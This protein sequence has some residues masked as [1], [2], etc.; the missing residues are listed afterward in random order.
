MNPEH[1]QAEFV[2]RFGDTDVLRTRDYGEAYDSYKVKCAILGRAYRGDLDRL[3]IDVRCLRCDGR[4]RLT[5]IAH[6]LELRCPRCDAIWYRSR[7]WLLHQNQ[8]LPSEQSNRKPKYR[9][10]SPLEERL[11]VRLLWSE[12]HDVE[13]AA[14]YLGRTPSAVNQKALKLARK[15]GLPAQ[16]IGMHQRAQAYILD[17]LRDGKPVYFSHDTLAS[18][19]QLS[20]N[21]IRVIFR[22]MLAE[23][24]IKRVD[25]GRYRLNPSKDKR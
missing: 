17:Q 16:Q 24:I 10:W 9:D 19:H 21:V 13:T 18:M 23:G 15:H 20:K 25:R 8:T 4:F 5:N 2:L 12:G 7:E 14:Y 11:L 1:M 6:P 3:H 22:R